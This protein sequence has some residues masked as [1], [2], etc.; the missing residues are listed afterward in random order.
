MKTPRWRIEQRGFGS[1]PSL[2]WRVQVSPKDA[3]H[4]DF[5]VEVEASL[6]GKAPPEFYA[7]AGFDD[8][9]GLSEEGWSTDG[10][11]TAVAAVLRA[12]TRLA[13][14][15]KELSELEPPTRRQLQA[16]VRAVEKNEGIR[17]RH[18]RQQRAKGARR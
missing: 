4:V 6:E 18:R 9:A 8:L 17:R 15:L 10:S 12:R 11:A 5:V 16:L 7:S 13:Y 3:V 14:V 2:T 1:R